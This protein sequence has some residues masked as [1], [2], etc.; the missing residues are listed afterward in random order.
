LILITSLYLALASRI[1]GGLLHFSKT[2]KNGLWAI[3]FGVVTFVIYKQEFGLEWQTYLA[4]LV[5]FAGGFLKGTGNGGGN[6]LA[7][8]PKEPGKG[9]K[10][11]KVEI[12]IYPWLYNRIPRY[13]YDVVL[14]S[15]LGLTAVIVPALVI[16]YCSLILGC[17]VALGGLL[18]GLAYIIGWYLF[19]NSYDERNTETGEALT[20]FFAGLFLGFAGVIG[21]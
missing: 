13:W 17:L 11:E 14:M 18:K 10:L 3:P 16:G 20:G 8:N 7:T 5:A 12:L 6:D 19:P 2:L 15:I 21:G 1:H 4:T 9:R